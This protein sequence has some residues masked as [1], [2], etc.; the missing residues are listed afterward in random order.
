MKKPIEIPMYFTDG[1]IKGAEKRFP[2]VEG[3]IATAKHKT[4]QF[5]KSAGDKI[6]NL[7]EVRKANFADPTQTDEAKAV[8]TWRY[9]KTKQ[10][11]VQKEVDTLPDLSTY[12]DGIRK[13]V[14][15][16]LREVANSD[17]GRE[18]RQR[19]ASLSDKERGKFVSD[20]MNSGDYDA[21]AYILGAPAYLSGISKDQHAKL[22]ER[23]VSDFYPREKQLVKSLTELHD[24]TQKGL[25]EYT[26]IMRKM[27]AD[28]NINEALS[29]AE[30]AKN[31]M[32]S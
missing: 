26:R 1:F 7:E 15:N 20:M 13:H 2:E 5:L 3:D 10:A 28:A 18:A 32:N 22:K 29:K 23:Y 27:K 19:I 30:K 21:P 9:A 12:A 16:E 4:T 6:R 11:E 31:L 8:N 14:D 17:F 25:K 24:T